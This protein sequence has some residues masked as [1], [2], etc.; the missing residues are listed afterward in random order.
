MND[1]HT[2]VMHTNEETV[3]LAGERLNWHLL[4][5]Q[6]DDE[7]VACAKGKPKQ[8]KISK[9]INSKAIKISKRLYKILLI[10]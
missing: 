4:E 2:K 6:Q 8:K 7:C 5:P 10:H 9:T 3:E 1:G